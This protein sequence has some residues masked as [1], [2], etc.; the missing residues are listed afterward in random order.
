MLLPGAALAA[1]QSAGAPTPGGSDQ[2]PHVFAPGAE[3]SANMKLV[4]HIPL[5]PRNSVSDIEVEHEAARPY[6]YVSRRLP[7]AGFDL[8]TLKD[9]KGA[10]LIYSWRIEN[11][12][13]H[14]G[15]G[16]MRGVYFKTKSRYYYAQ[17][18]QFRQSGP[19]SDVGA[20]VFD[21]TSLPDVSKIREVGRVRA[22]DAPGGFHN[23]YAY[24]HSD[25]R[26]L[27]FA[28]SGP[29]AKVYDMDKFLAGA[30]DQGLLGTVPVPANPGD[31]SKGYHDFYVG[32]DVA[33]QQDKFYGAG[34]G[35]YY[36]FDV[37]QP[38]QPALLSTIVGVNGFNWGH[39]FTP[40][41][42]GK[43]AV[44]EAEWQYQPLRI[45]DLKP[46]GQTELRNINRP[47][48]AWQANWQTVAH[49]HEVRWPYVFVSGYETGL[50]V[51]NMMDP[52]NPYTVGY[53]DTY[54][55]QHNKGGMAGSA[56]GNF[57]WGVYDGVWGVDVRNADGIVVVSDMTSGFWAFKMEGF[58][59]WNGNDWGMPNI[60]SAQDW[61]KGPEGVR[62]S[63]APIS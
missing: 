19:D 14:Q 2:L 38:Q 6:V 33:T 22:P 45:F 20:I 42:D 17:S 27:M 9:P 48:G 57:T 53:F 30:P 44:G 23:I 15:S 39:T 41:P 61:D 37:T 47:I 58:D 35:G 26:A 16:G 34:G 29:G 21:V 7:Q 31:L 46:A 8:I 18:V 59:G 11:L 50:S 5:G 24:K 56:S 13:L 60:S 1:Q 49:N 4:A 28:T 32:F 10:K 25:G 54:N 51:F 62:K 3:R 55:G 12:E 36:V 43:Y 63:A 52:T 40:T